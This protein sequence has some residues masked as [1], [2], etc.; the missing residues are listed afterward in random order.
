MGVRL[1]QKQTSVTG[2]T[3]PIL[4]PEA[5]KAGF[6]I[7]EATF[8]TNLGRSPVLAPI[9]IKPP[10]TYFSKLIRNTHAVP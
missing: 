3:H 6:S 8:L 5:Q 2:L 7:L 1:R 9:A 10:E 4:Q